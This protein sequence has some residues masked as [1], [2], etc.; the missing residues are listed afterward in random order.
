MVT[1]V[2]EQKSSTKGSPLRTKEMVKTALPTHPA[3]R[4]SIHQAVTH[5]ELIMVL[6]CDKAARTE[7]VDHSEWIC[8]QSSWHIP[9]TTTDISSAERDF[10]DML[11]KRL[12][13]QPHDGCEGP[14]VLSRAQRAICQSTRSTSSPKTSDISRSSCGTASCNTTISPETFITR[15]DFCFSQGSSPVGLIQ[16]RSEHCHCRA[17]TTTNTIISSF[18][19]SSPKRP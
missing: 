9:L 16:S 2:E 19:Q 10:P 11:G 14:S 5:R 7:L 8:V 18:Q 1:L 4:L 13:P 17:V 6:S 15:P 12:F 3:I